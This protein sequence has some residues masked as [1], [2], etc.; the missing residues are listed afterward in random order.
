MENTEKSSVA[1]DCMIAL[2]NAER[3]GGDFLT[4][5]AENLLRLEAIHPNVGFRQSGQAMLCGIARRA[6]R[7]E[8]RKPPTSV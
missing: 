8:I 1:R 4:N 7:G 2:E 3:T 5:V 6:E